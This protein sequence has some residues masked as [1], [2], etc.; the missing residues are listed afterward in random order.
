[1]VQQHQNFISPIL[2]KSAAQK[3]KSSIATFEKDVRALFE[4]G[5][6]DEEQEN[7]MDLNRIDQLRVIAY[8]ILTQPQ[9]I[10]SLFFYVWTILISSLSVFIMLAGTSSTFQITPAECHYCD[11]SVDMKFDAAF[12]TTR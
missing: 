10:I 12:I 9:N 6:I 7:E 2:T 11:D 5:N 3:I 1:M 4:N 8:K